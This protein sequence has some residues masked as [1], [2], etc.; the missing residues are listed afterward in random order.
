MITILAGVIFSTTTFLLVIGI[1]GTCLANVNKKTREWRW[2][3][4]AIWVFLWASSAYYLF[5]LW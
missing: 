4:L 5:G 2:G 1:V 3:N